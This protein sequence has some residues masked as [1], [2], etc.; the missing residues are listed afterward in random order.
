MRSAPRGRT[1]AGLLLYRRASGGPEV[2]LGHPGGPYWANKDDGAWTIPKGE[3]EPG[4]DLLAAARREFVEETGQ[5]IT[6]PVTPL[7]SA[8]QS[9]GKT[10][11]IFASEGDFDPGA[12]VSVPFDMEWPP[13]SGRSQSFPEIDRA[14]WFDL[15][16][17]RV[18][19]IKGQ[20]IFLDRLRD[21]LAAPPRRT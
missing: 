4:E 10:V 5:T 3:P 12:L 11:H 19:I 14:Q 20:A 9:S 8:R 2:L 6:A 17:A 21:M 15:D 1:S 13:R 7:G 16:A 18:K